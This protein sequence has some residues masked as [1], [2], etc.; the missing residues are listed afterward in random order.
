LNLFRI[1]TFQEQTMSSSISP[2]IGR[3][4]AFAAALLLGVAG[5]SESDPNRVPTFPVQGTVLLHGAPVP[6]AMVVLHPKNSASTAPPASGHVAP[7]GA[8]TVTT[9][10][11]NDGAAEGEYTVTVT[12]HRP[13]PQ[14]DGFKPGPNVLPRKYENAA[15]SDLVVRIA[16]GEN[17]LPALELKR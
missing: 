8:F 9:Y 3:A 14:G 5:C 17:R 6:G 7:D 10:E 1:S 2:H 15:T 4:A 16:Q 13:V 12:L 11:G